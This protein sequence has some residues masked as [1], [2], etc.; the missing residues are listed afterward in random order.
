MLTIPTPSRK[1]P[2][3]S[4]PTGAKADSYSPLCG[5][6]NQGHWRSGPSSSYSIEEYEEDDT[7]D[8]LSIRSA[9]SGGLKR[10]KF[11]E[12][13]L[14][15]Q[16]ADYECCASVPV[17]PWVEQDGR[18]SPIE[19]SNDSE[20]PEPSQKEARRDREE[21]EDLKASYVK[22]VKVYEGEYILH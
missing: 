20:Q 8:Q 14:Y 7:V 6:P 5:R 11:S 4:Q 16:E 17:S 2:R 22:A 13:T 3:E 18:L 21:W 19:I 12:Q 15:D 10:R 9:S 1:R